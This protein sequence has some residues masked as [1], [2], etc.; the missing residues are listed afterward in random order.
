MSSPT[1]SSYHNISYMMGLIM[2]NIR[3]A[4][5]EKKLEKLLLEQLPDKKYPKWVVSVV[6]VN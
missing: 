5:Q 2:D 6:I 3:K 1:A 4:I